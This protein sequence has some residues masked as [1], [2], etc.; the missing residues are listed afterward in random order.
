M[1]SKEMVLN[2]FL[3]IIFMA[4]L[5]I[6]SM[7]I[8]E[9]KRDLIFLLTIPTMFLTVFIL[10]FGTPSKNSEKDIERGRQLSTECKLIE[11]NIADN[12][13]RFSCKD[14]GL[15]MKTPDAKRSIEAYKNSLEKQG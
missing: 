11:I 2:G 10:I 8:Q 14:V 9:G 1:E 4:S 15:V 13:S 5:A 6:C 7:R 3:F 12:T